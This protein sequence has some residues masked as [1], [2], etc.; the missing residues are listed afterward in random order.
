MLGQHHNLP[1]VKPVMRHLAVDR[2]HHRVRFAADGHRAAKV[3]I[4]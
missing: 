4:R 2:L 1:Y 3:R